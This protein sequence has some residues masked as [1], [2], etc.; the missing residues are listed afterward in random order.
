MSSTEEIAMESA[1]DLSDR[2]GVR[3]ETMKRKY[4]DPTLREAFAA[5]AREPRSRKD[6]PAPERLWAA[7]RGEL[8]VSERHEL[9]DHTTTCPSCAETWRMAILM[10]AHPP[11]R[12]RVHLDG[13]Q[14]KLAEAWEW[15]RQPVARPVLVGG[16]QM[17]QWDRGALASMAGAL[18]LVAVVLFQT[19]DGPQYREVYR[20]GIVAQT[21]ANVPLARGDFRLRW[22]GPNDAL[23]YDLKVMTASLES[24]VMIEGLEN[25]EYL[26]SERDLEGLAAGEYLFWI[27][28][29]TLPTGERIT[30]PTFATQLQ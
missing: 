30:S 10:G 17:F 16:W 12:W 4:D 29:A 23:L 27:V 7:I 24:V 28:E 18:V 6:C 3:G 13:F 26:L 21:G 14:D 22:L 2:R 15:L 25:S 5:L 11:P 9:I 20:G 8:E 19:A 1:S